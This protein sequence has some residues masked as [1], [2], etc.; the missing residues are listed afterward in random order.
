MSHPIKHEPNSEG[1]EEYEWGKKSDPPKVEKIQPGQK[2]KPNFGLSVKLAEDK[3]T[4]NGVFIKYSEPPE[5][6]KS[7]IRWRLYPFEG[8]KCLPPLHIHRQSAYLIG[9]DRKVADIP[10]DYPSCSRQHA[11]LQYRLVPSKR[12]DG[13]SDYRLR[14]YIIDLESSHGTFVNNMKI[15]PVTYVDLLEK[16]VI[17]FGYSSREYVLLREDSTG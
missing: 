5:A 13:T 16:D 4:F 9:R 12:E 10:V 3:N 7:K 2:E 14:P 8:D 15:E 1:E 17:R 6:C 11:A